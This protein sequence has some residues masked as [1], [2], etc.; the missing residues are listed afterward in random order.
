MISN[1]PI[2]TDAGK[3][4]LLRALAG[5]SV[6]FTRF[7]IGSG[8]LPE[9]ADPAELTDLVTP[10]IAFGV[11][12][13]DA[14]HEGYL[15]ISGK[16]GSDD[17][18][19][20]FYWRELGIFAKGEDNL[21]TLYAYSNDGDS[22]DLLKPVGSSV[23]T[24]QTVTMIVEIGDAADVHVDFVP[25][26]DVIDII[27][28]VGSIYMSVNSTDPGSLFTGTTWVRIKDTF[29]LAAGDDYEA[30]DTGG[31]AEH[32]LTLDE[33]PAHD[34]GNY[35]YRNGTQF[36]WAELQPTG[37]HIDMAMLNSVGGGQA[38]NNMPPYLAVYMWKR[39]A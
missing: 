18:L 30:G 19:S 1:T 4:L 39:T 17:I 38:H 7:K 16:F 3:S 26:P 31:E 36:G 9:G 37:S 28:P 27:Y 23:V 22:A 24:Q 33:V 32:T 2:L 8:Y 35:V 25:P 20:E 11:T 15:G 34:H 14:S 6:T 5:E 29:L 21:E 13:V 12:S 10:V